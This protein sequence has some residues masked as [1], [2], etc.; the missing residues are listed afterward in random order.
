MQQ[1]YRGR[2]LSAGETAA[3]LAAWPRGA[4]VARYRLLAP[5][6]HWRLAAHCAARARRGDAG[7]GDALRLELAALTGA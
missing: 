6:L 1:L 2:P 4:E 5:L 3:F 7:Y